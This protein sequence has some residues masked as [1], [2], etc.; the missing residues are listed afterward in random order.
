MLQR[1]QQRSSHEPCQNIAVWTEQDKQNGNGWAGR[2]MMKLSTVGNMLYKTRLSEPLHHLLTLTLPMSAIAISMAH[3]HS[4]FLSSP[5]HEPNPLR[6]PRKQIQ[7][8]I[9][10]HGNHAHEDVAPD[11]SARDR[12]PNLGPDD[13]RSLLALV[14]PDEAVERYE[15]RTEAVQ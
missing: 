14:W 10:C 1:I 13:L 12:L 8:R 5:D 4:V 11:A 3:H 9:E 2:V 7:H 15:G 6:N